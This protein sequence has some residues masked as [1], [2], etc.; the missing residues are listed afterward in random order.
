MEIDKFP[1]V[2]DRIANMAEGI[3]SEKRC[4]TPQWSRELCAWDEV[5]EGR[6]FVH[7]EL[8]GRLLETGLLGGEMSYEEEL[9]PRIFIPLE[10]DLR[11]LFLYIAAKEYKATDHTQDEL[12]E[13]M[14]I[15]RE[16]FDAFLN[17]LCEEGL[18]EKKGQNYEIVKDGLHEAVQR[19]K[20]QKEITALQKMAPPLP[21]EEVYE[22]E[23]VD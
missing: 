14:Q 18:I 11:N 16:E 5:S 19:F 6:E 23:I 15:N 7:E 12:Q 1:G 3:V 9:S 17:T 4:I 21:S 20:I 2:D 13:K 8:N 10:D 22:I